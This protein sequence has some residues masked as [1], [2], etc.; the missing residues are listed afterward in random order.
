MLWK[1]QNASKD[2]NIVEQFSGNSYV[3]SHYKGGVWLEQWENTNYDDNDNNNKKLHYFI[4]NIKWVYKSKYIIWLKYS[5]NTALGFQIVFNIH[6]T[7]EINHANELSTTHLFSSVTY[8]LCI[9][10]DISIFTFLK[11]TSFQKITRC[12]SLT[13]RLLIWV[14]TKDPH[15][16]YSTIQ[17]Q[18]VVKLNKNLPLS[19]PNKYHERSSFYLNCL[20]CSFQDTDTKWFITALMHSERTFPSVRRKCLKEVLDGES[21]V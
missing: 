4:F 6:V 7:L 10:A 2:Q 9:K 8:K 16:L 18:S 15:S 17:N 19:D 21:N 5:L 20:I 3:F 13:D 14:Y 12:W 1:W 11:R